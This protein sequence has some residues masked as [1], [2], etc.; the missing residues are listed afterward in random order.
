MRNSN[1]ASAERPAGLGDA[2]LDRTAESALVTHAEEP[3]ADHLMGQCR[4]CQSYTRALLEEK[5]SGRLKKTVTV[6]AE[7]LVVGAYENFTERVDGPS[8]LCSFLIGGRYR[9]C[10]DIA[11]SLAFSVVDLLMGGRGYPPVETRPLGELEQGFLHG[12]FEALLSDLERSWRQ[13]LPYEWKIAQEAQFTYTL[14][15]FQVDDP[16][17]VLD[18]DVSV[19][20]LVQARVLLGVPLAAVVSP[21]EMGIAAPQ[22]V[23]EDPLRSPLVGVLPIRVQAVLPSAELVVQRLLE[24]EEGDTLELTGWEMAA[25]DDDTLQVLVCIEGAP[26][27]VGR[28]GAAGNRKAVE[29]LCEVEEAEVE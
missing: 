20:D 27:F 5:L 29:I 28:L 4:V 18:F 11:Q 10:M 19:E 6:A 1:D 14:D 21:G 23:L 13:L 15:G 3:K 22:E 12:I 26:R 25:T 2:G 17:L 8:S 16:M 24:L 7:E 9:A